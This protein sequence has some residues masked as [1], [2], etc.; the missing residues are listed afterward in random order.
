MLRKSILVI[1]VMVLGVGLAQAQMKDSSSVVHV[2]AGAEEVE[3]TPG[4]RVPLEI[5]VDIDK[6]WHIYAHGDTNFIGLDLV[7]DEFFPLLDLQAEYPAGHEGEFFGEKVF[8]IEGSN[9]IKASAQIADGMPA[10]EYPL[11]FEVV[12]QACDDK[13]CLAPANVP[14]TVNLKVQSGE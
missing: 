8:M 14:V 4:Q 3:G 11:K 6:K 2:K 7:P 9:V 12:V 1:M 5:K 13:T 10:G